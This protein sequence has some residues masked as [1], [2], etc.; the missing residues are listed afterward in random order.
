MAPGSRPDVPAIEVFPTSTAP[1]GHLAAIRRLVD[2]AFGSEFAETDWEHALGGWH[3]VA[4]AKGTV[5]SHAA[6]VPRHLWFGHRELAAGYLEA[7]ATDPAVQ[8]HGIGSRVMDQAATLLRR[9]FQVGAL[10]TGRPSFY[11]RLGWER[12]QGPSSVWRGDE[13]LPTPEDDGGLMVLRF[14]FGDD[15]VL[16][17]A[18]T[19]EPRP[20]DDW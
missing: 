16:T 2:A 9:E 8:G 12:W 17:E 14:G 7:V 1:D 19:C 15:L 10:A 4:V 5:V 18:M 20:G 13:R 6:V 11:E 3:V